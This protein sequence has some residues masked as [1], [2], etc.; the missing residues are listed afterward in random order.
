MHLPFEA[1]EQQEEDAAAG[2][3]RRPT[4]ELATDAVARRALRWLLPANLEKS[5][6]ESGESDDGGGGRADGATE[7]WIGGERALLYLACNGLEESALLTLEA[8]LGGS[9]A[10]DDVDGFTALH[11]AA[12][13]GLVRLAAA[14]LARGAPHAATTRDVFGIG[15]SEPGGRTALH[16]AAAAGSKDI[17]ARLLDGGADAR[18]QD[19]Q[20]ATPAVLA[21]RRGNFGLAAEIGKRAAA[22]PAEEAEAEALPTE[23]ELRAMEMAEGMALRARAKARRHIDDRPPLHAPFV[24]PALLD[25]TGCDAVVRDV[26][27]AA[28]R[29]GG[30]MNARHAHAATR[31]LPL[32]AGVPARRYAALRAL[33]DGVVLPAMRARYAT[34]RLRVKEAFVVK[35]EAGLSSAGLEMHRDG[36]LLNCVILLSSPSDFEGGGTA[37][38]PPL[39]RTWTTARGD[40]LC[41]CGQLS[42]GAAVVTKGVRY[43]LIAF[44]DEEQE[45][46]EEEGE[47]E[48]LV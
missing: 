3:K 6:G 10:A 38:A 4:A 23:Q 8:G 7:A 24:L 16:L 41:S 29:R 47:E 36:T 48:E 9:L 27:R 18:A 19:W 2:A 45:V 30:W 42:H 46:E 12:N 1:E 15:V 32:H 11:F 44:I 5:D 21:M 34:R 40:G 31:D 22:A 17:A 35:Y 33:L 43:T 39:G 20:G 14:L 37:F 28:A 26:E 25:A 13:L